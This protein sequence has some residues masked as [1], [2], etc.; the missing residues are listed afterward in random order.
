M[1]NNIHGMMKLVNNNACDTQRKLL[2]NTE[3]T[4]GTFYSD[5]LIIARGMFGKKI[6]NLTQLFRRFAISMANAPFMSHTIITLKAG[7]CT[8]NVRL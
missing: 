3:L 4:I 8:L 2:R 5:I 1:L 6:V 7:L